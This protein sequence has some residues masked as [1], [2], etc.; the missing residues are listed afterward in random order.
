MKTSFLSNSM[1]F[2]CEFGKNSNLHSM[3][4]VF[5]T[6]SSVAWTSFFTGANP[7][8]HG[9]FGFTDRHLNPFEIYIPTA[10]NRKKNPIWNSISSEAKVNVVN[11][12]LTYPPQKVNGNMV[13]CFLSPDINRATYPEKLKEYLEEIGYIIDVD[14]WM[15]RKDME[16]FINQLVQALRK[17]FELAFTLLKNNWNYF[18]LHIMETDRLLHFAINY[19]LDDYE[20]KYSHLLKKFFNLLDDY[21]LQL[22]EVIKDKAAF[23]ILSD[24][25][26]CRI[27]YEVELNVWLQHQ[28]FL[29]FK[30]QERHLLNY[31]PD[32][33]CY[34]LTPGRIYL[35]LAGREQNGSIS[36]QDYYI[37]RDKIKNA[38]LSITNPYTKEPVV[39]RVLYREEI[40]QGEFLHYA[41][42]LLIH[43][44]NGYDFK[45]T[46]NCNK[47][48][49]VSTIKGM[50]TYEDAIILGSNIDISSVFQITDVYNII[51]SYLR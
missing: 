27:K 24:H 14:A 35:N 37:V 29:N 33:I 17:R 32:S 1:P 2:L 45:S 41:P 19:L 9:I 48:F 8:E 21:I 30:A 5:P 40:Y 15:A 36:S 49:N 50:H 43:P 20:K 13:S 23:I 16:S 47:I 39:K 25:G 42:D 3:F 44:I 4:S 11:V 6:V 31:S 7:G 12:P 18:Q 38:L 22:Y 34:A 26:F 28:G 10:R 46:L 51:K